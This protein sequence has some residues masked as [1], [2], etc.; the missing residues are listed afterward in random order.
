MEKY[1]GAA[2]LR[3]FSQGIFAFLRAFLAFLLLFSDLFMIFFSIQ[4]SKKD[5]FGAQGLVFSYA[6]LL[7]LIGLR[8]IW[9]DMRVSFLI[10]KFS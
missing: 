2:F 5:A 9:A 4:Y 6:A 10:S 3:G 1:F 7:F 8:G